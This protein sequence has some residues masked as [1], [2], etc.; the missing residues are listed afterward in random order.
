[1][2]LRPVRLLTVADLAAT[3][4][5]A[6]EG[7]ALGAAAGLD[8]FGVL[9]VAS[10][11]AVGG[12]IIRDLLLGD[13]PPAALRSVAYP[14][15]ITIGWLLVVV[16]YS[17]VRAIPTPVLVTL[18]AAG[19]ALFCVVGATKALDFTVNPVFAVLLGTVTGVG[20]GILRDLLLREVPVVLRTDIYAVAAGLGAVV[21]VVARHFGVPRAAAMAAGAVACLT[22]RL[23]SAAFGWHLPQV[24]A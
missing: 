12:G 14:A 7:G 6:V 3:M 21:L 10:A 24:T 19:L 18:D 22:L 11:T 8:L 1:M 20:G 23:V 9:V 13:V 17:G 15:V 16:L 4:L 5:F 2:R